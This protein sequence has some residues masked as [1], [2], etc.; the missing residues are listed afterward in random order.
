MRCRTSHT[1]RQTLFELFLQC[2]PLTLG[3]G[4]LAAQPNDRLALIMG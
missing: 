4:Q 2:I 1:I 3:L